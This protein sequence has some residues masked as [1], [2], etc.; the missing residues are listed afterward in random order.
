MV[1]PQW[2]VTDEIRP[3]HTGLPKGHTFDFLE[4]DVQKL[5]KVVFQ[6]LDSIEV[7]ISPRLSPDRKR[8]GLK[9]N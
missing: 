1:P 4:D 5:F 9:G 6:K 2:Q 7:Q 3:G 8:I